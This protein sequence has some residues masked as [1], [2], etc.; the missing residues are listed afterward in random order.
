MNS[1]HI[2]FIIRIKNGYLA[3]KQN[4]SGMYSKLNESIAEILKKEGYIKSFKVTQDGNK[5]SISVELLYNE[6]EPAIQGVKIYSRPGQRHY[7]KKEEIKSV[8]GGLGMS[9]V[10]TPLG[11]MTN[12]HAR[13][14]KTGGE[15]LYSIW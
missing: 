11:V 6:D 8:L 4:A 2:D 10:S 3:Q 12:K 14:N 7:V 9:I 1:T 5:K 15:I 13:K